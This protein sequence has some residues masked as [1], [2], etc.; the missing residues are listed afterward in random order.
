MTSNNDDLSSKQSDS[1][2]KGDTEVKT[3]NVDSKT[4]VLSH[5]DAKA[6]VTE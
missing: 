2:L 3:E 5:E 6:K 4:E 1:S